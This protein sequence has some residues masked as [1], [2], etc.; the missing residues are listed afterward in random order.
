MK[1]SNDEYVEI[2]E[3]LARTCVWAEI[4]KARVR[5]KLGCDSTHVR[6]LEWIIEA[7]LE[8]NRNLQH[9]CCDGPPGPNV[10]LVAD[11]RWTHLSLF[12]GGE[13]REARA[14]TR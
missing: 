8:V 14:V 12:G 5:D 10:R 4:T 11:G 9:E 13:D 7:L 2:N 1:L 6:H 3:A